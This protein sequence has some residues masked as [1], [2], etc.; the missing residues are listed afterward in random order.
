[1]SGLE[2]LA[3]LSMVVIILRDATESQKKKLIEFLR[4]KEEEDVPPW[5]KQEVAPS[6]AYEDSVQTPGEELV[7][8]AITNSNLYKRRMKRRK[9]SLIEGVKT[10]HR[11]RKHVEVFKVQHD[12]GRKPCKRCGKM[13]TSY[14][15]QAA[16]CKPV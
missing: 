4:K 13:S 7:L 5:M 8:S 15:R 11:N 12:S 2:I 6:R 14:H 9:I 16:N 3:E 10:H 1:M